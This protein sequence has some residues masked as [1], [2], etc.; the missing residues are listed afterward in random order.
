MLTDKQKDRLQ[1]ADEI[2]KEH[3]DDERYIKTC[4]TA[5]LCPECDGESLW[6]DNMSLCGESTF[7][8]PDCKKSF[9]I[10]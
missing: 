7:S 10:T 6:F 1:R 8:C 9:T 4:I 5:G 2:L 3:L